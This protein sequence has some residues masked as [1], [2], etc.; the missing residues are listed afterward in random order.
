MTQSAHSKVCPVCRKRGC[1]NQDHKPKPFAS[2][3]PR[4]ERRPNYDK[5][6][7]QRK[8]AVLEWIEIWGLYCPI[9]GHKDTFTDGTAVRLTANHIY[10]V[11]LGGDEDGPMRVH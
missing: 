4:S 5:Y 9:C 6:R 10:P 3:R 2:S 8:A 7:A 1:V 11:A